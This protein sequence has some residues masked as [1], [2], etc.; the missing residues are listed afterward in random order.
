FWRGGS[1]L[2]KMGGAVLGHLL[3]KNFRPSDRGQLVPPRRMDAAVCRAEVCYPFGREH[4]RHR[5]VRRRE[6][7][8]LL[9]GAA[10]WPFAARV[11]P[12]VP[13]V[14]YLNPASPGAGT[15]LAAGVPPR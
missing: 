5:A 8:T 15:T 1:R 13:V 12:A 11:Q 4:G 2:A 9:G 10:A 14:G 6:L 3:R 7:V